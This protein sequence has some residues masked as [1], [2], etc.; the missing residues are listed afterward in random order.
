MVERR[1]VLSERCGAHGAVA[2]G[3]DVVE[4]VRLRQGRLVTRDTAKSA[5]LLAEVMVHF[6]RKL[7]GVDGAPGVREEVIEVRETVTLD[8]GLGKERQHFYGNGVEAVRRNAMAGQGQARGGRAE[9]IVDG[10]QVTRRPQGLA[11]VAGALAGSRQR[12]AKDVA[13]PIAGA[14]IVAEEEG[15]VAPHRPAHRAPELIHAKRG[16]RAPGAFGEELV[17]VEGAVPQVFI[18]RA[19]EGIGAG[20]R[21]DIHHAAAEASPLGGEVVALHL[22]LLRGFNGGNRRDLVEEAGGGRYAVDLDLVAL[23]A[24]AIDREVRVPGGVDGNVAE[25]PTGGAG[26]ENAGSKLDQP[27]CATPIERNVLDLRVIDQLPERR[28]LGIQQSGLG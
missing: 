13:A 23:G 26:A 16:N 5:P 15:A 8:V 27:K 1:R 7:I 12:A 28:R 6:A 3:G 19:V 18:Q 20:A 21:A 10:G 4:I 14:L 25:L 2:G 9:R 11:E 24:A 22:E 17:G